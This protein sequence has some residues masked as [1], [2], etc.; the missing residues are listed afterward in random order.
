MI[1]AIATNILTSISLCYLNFPHYIILIF[2]GGVI[3]L[4]EVIEVIGLRRKQYKEQY[5]S[6]EY[7]KFVNNLQ[8]QQS[9]SFLEHTL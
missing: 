4:N 8:L 6:T 7:L 3:L 9:L 1:T 2:P 5:N